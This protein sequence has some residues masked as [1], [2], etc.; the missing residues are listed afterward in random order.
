MIKVYN[1][2]ID[3]RELIGA[4]PLWSKRS[5][6][7]LQ[8]TVYKEYSFYFEVYTRG[9]GRVVITSDWLSFM[10]SNA[11]G[12]KM[13]QNA[14]TEAHKALRRC[15]IDGV[16]TDLLIFKEHEHKIDSE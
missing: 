11:E 3:E 2:V 6:D 8:V 12:A 4:G 15:L 7:P 10:G 14:I 9:G 5:A 1:T 13:E 16:F